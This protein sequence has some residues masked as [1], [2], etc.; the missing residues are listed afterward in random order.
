L[1][2]VLLKLLAASVD[3]IDE[4]VADSAIARDSQHPVPSAVPQIGEGELQEGE[5]GVVDLPLP[6]SEIDFGRVLQDQPDQFLLDT[7]PGGLRWLSNDFLDLADRQGGRD[8]E[9]GRPETLG[10]ER[11]QLQ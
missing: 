7:L 10:Q 11:G 3:P 8:V 2:V 9:N 4:G 5:D 1:F 6:T